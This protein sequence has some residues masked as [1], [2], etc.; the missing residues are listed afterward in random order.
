MTLPLDNSSACIWKWSW[1]TFRLYTG[2]SSSCHRIKSVFVH[3]DDFND[4]HNTKEVINDRDLM[5]KGVWPKDR[6][7]EY[8][9]EIEDSGGTSDRTYHNPMKDFLPLDL[10]DDSLRATPRVLELYLDNACDLACVYCV[11]HY[12]SKINSELSRFG[13]NVLGEASVKR[14]EHHSQYLKL[15]KEWLEINGKNLKRLSILGGEPL[16]QKEFWSLLDWLSN[17]K[18]PDLELSIVT[19]LNSPI[20]KVE[21]LIEDTKRLISNKQIKKFDL[22]ASIDCWGPQQK[23]IRYGL[24]LD[25]WEDNFRYLVEHR[26]LSL[27]VHPVITNLSIHT[28]KDMQDRF[29]SFKKIKP[30]LR[31]DYHLVDGLSKEIYHPII[32]DRSFYGNKMQDLIDSFEGDNQSKDRLIGIARVVEKSVHDFSRLK[33][34]KSQLDQYKI[35]RS[36]DWEK[37]FPEVEEYFRERNVV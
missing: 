21:K 31:I 18:H 30:S 17:H 36:L 25:R 27:A 6:G 16:L 12:S 37:I 22:I 35:R 15:M 26:W 4:F 23:F 29:N 8:C 9:K 24:D 7:C 32:F 33:R 2:R 10:S 3:P 5:L 13:P 11:P 34:L 19:N 28:A 14:T 20:E 1:N